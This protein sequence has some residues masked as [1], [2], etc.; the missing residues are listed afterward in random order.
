[1]THNL[2][3]KNEIDKRTRSLVSTHIWKM[4]GPGIWIRI[5]NGTVNPVEDEV[6]SVRRSIWGQLDD[7]TIDIP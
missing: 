5:V 2:P 1:M 4:I 6:T 3:V 7:T